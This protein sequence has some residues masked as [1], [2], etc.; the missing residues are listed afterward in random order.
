MIDTIVMTNTPTLCSF[1]PFGIVVNKSSIEFGD[2]MVV[3][4]LHCDIMRG[5]GILTG[6]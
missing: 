6:E 4:C 2:M 5:N 3:F 1:S